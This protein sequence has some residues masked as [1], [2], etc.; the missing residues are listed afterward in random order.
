MN[1][2]KWKK[3]VA[4]VLAEESTEPLSWFYCSFADHGG[5]RGALF[6]RAKGP[7]H[8]IREATK[9]G[10]NPGGEVMF[11]KLKDTDPIPDG[12]YLNRLLD[13]KTLQEAVGPIVRTDG[14]DVA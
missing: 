14:A 2:A 9:L 8:L 11:V 12:K 6:M 7:T 10:I 3:R 5:F 13:K 1:K 4:Q